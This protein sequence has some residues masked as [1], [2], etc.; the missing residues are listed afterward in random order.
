VAAAGGPDRALRRLAAPDKLGR[1]RATKQQKPKGRF[2][3]TCIRKRI[4]R[5]CERI[6]QH[7]SCPGTRQPAKFTEIRIILSRASVI[8][9]P[10]TGITGRAEDSGIRHER[11]C[12]RA[13]HR[14][15]E[16]PGGLEG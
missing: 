13:A 7:G 3:K 8:Q 4:D 5:I 15:A 9:R 11:P 14:G 16:R 10:S 12:D 6:L 2:G 1:Y